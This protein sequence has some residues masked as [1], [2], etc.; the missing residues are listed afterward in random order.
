MFHSLETE[1]EDWK[2]RPL[3]AHY[4][5]AYADGT[6]FTVIYNEEGCKMPI[7]AI[8]GID[9]EGKP[10][11]GASAKFWL[12]AWANGRTRTPGKTCWKT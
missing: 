3:K 1:F 4:L 5:Y 8:V 11:A 10:P 7:L 9:E 2:T 12:S 6:Y